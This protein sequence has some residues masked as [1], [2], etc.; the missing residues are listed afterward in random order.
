ME[1]DY[2]STR[3]EQELQASLQNFSIQEIHIDVAND[4]K[5]ETAYKQED[6]YKQ[7]DSILESME[8]N[9]ETNKGKTVYV[10]KPT[11]SFW[12]Y[13]SRHKKQ[14]EMSHLI[15]RKRKGD[16]EVVYNMPAGVREQKALC[17]AIPTSMDIEIYHKLFEYQIQHVCNIANLICTHGVCL[18]MSHTGTGKTY[19]AAAV[20]SHLKLKAMI[21]CPKIIISN[22]IDACYYM[23]VELLGVFSWETLRTCNTNYLI[24]NGDNMQWIL[25][26]DSIIIF[27]EAHKAKDYQTKNAEMVIAATN[28]GIRQL[29]LSATIADNPMHLGA[30]GYGLGLFEHLGHFL[31]W[32][33]DLGCSKTKY[34]WKFTGGPQHIQRLKGLLVAKSSKMSS[35]FLPDTQIAA[36]AYNYEYAAEI[37]KLYDDIQQGVEYYKQAG[38]ATANKLT[39]RLRA[40]QQIELLKVKLLCDIIEEQLEIGFSV[41]V[42]CNYKDTMFAL[43]ETYPDFAEVHGEQTAYV[44]QLEVARFQSNVTRGIILQISA[45]GV[46]VSLHDVDGRYPRYSIICPTDSAQDM[47]Q[48]FGRVHRAGGKSKSIQRVV[49]VAGTVEQNVCKVVQLKLLRM[50]T[51]TDSDLQVM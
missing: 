35:E 14:V 6:V 7:L 5:Q 44:R 27:D 33:A 10:A 18:D 19:T 9:Y 12:M 36:V 23:G 39:R 4:T 47:T 50:N 46:G 8:W 24:H 13:Y 51:I 45:G 40:R 11:Q 42:F 17:L 22:W 29:Y 30:I 16:W 25:P 1:P 3:L 49:Y 20:V 21:C 2:L 43:K 48:A 41:V 32:A 28:Q 37:A 34:G 15:V 31:K 38:E 26:E